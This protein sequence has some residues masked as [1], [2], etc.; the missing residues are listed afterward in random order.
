MDRFGQI[1]VVQRNATMPA[2]RIS[3]QQ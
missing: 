3:R 1:T 2:K